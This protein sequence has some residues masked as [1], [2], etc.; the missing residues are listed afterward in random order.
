M[1]KKPPVRRLSPLKVVEKKTS[2]GGIML[3]NYG[4][5]R[6]AY[7]TQEGWLIL[8]DAG[9][10]VV[11]TREQAEGFVAGALGLTTGPLAQTKVVAYVVIK[12]VERV[13]SAR[14]KAREEAKALFDEKL[15]ESAD[16]EEIIE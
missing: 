1:T 14:E 3:S 12:D 9:H 2:K 13:M 15:N 4:E 8:D 10:A 5:A 16:D 6:V 11:K 7:H